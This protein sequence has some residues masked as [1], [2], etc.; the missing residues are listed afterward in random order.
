[1]TVIDLTGSPVG[2]SDRV[3]VGLVSRSMRMFCGRKVRFTLKGLLVCASEIGN[4]GLEDAHLVKQNVGDYREFSAKFV[5]KMLNR[6]RH[7]LSLPHYHAENVHFQNDAI[8]LPSSLLARRNRF[9][10]A[11]SFQVKKTDVCI[12]FESLV[13]GIKCSPVF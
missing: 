4:P 1:M 2:S 7:V 5:W 13:S 3:I 12:P 8:S 6:S 11:L 9:G 10:C